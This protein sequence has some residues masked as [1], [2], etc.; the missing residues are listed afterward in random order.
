M[1]KLPHNHPAAC[2]IVNYIHV[3]M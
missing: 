2:G 3:V 1:S